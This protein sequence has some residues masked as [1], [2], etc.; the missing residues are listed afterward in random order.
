M[1]KRF[2]NGVKR[3]KFSAIAE[4][5]RLD[6]IS[7]SN[8]VSLDPNIKSLAILED[9]EYIPMGLVDAFMECDRLASQG[10]VQFCG[11]SMFDLATPTFDEVIP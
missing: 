4:I 2:T 8:I 7:P 6:Q 1:A 11:A 5:K 10:V 9:I 3:K